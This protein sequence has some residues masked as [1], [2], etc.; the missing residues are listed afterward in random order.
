MSSID[1]SRVTAAFRS[2]AHPA[3]IVAVARALRQPVR[4]DQ[5]NHARAQ[6]GPDGAWP[7][8]KSGSRRRRILGRLPGAIRME[9]RGATIAAVSKVAWSGAHQDGPT[10]VGRGA[11]VPARQFLWISDEL[12]ALAERS[13]VDASTRE[14]R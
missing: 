14:F 6:E 11:V 13:L 3:V 4:T 2:A 12:L 10:R 8:R 9:V 7:A 1:V 5:R